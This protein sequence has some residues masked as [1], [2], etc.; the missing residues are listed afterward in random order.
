MR[1]RP[2]KVDMLRA[3]AR[4][5]EK[6]VRPALLGEVTGTSRDV[7]ALAFRVLIAAHLASVVAA[8]IAAEDDLDEAELTRLAALAGKEPSVPRRRTERRMAALSQ[9]RDL[10]ASLRE[11]GLSEAEERRIFEHVRATLKEELAVTNPR[12]D[13]SADLD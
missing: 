1:D 3:V 4:F 10:A 13:T 5:L 8:E 6:E 2:D 7:Q 11:G 12:F 9:T